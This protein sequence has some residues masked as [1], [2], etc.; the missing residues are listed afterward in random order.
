MIFVI[1]KML[2]V[3]KKYTRLLAVSSRRHS[4]DQ[5]DR[6]AGSGWHRDYAPERINLR[7][8][9]DHSSHQPDRR[10]ATGAPGNSAASGLVGGGKRGRRDGKRLFPALQQDKRKERFSHS[11]I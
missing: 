9:E 4:R 8:I 2:R 10:D 3:A 6:G 1:N 7:I 11:G 5:G